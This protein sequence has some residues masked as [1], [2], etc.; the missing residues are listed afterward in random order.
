MDKSEL[1]RHMLAARRAIPPEEA[2]ARS[3]AIGARIVAFD[4][5][6]TA[7]LVFAYVSS[8]DNEV[9]TCILIRELLAKGRVVAVPKACPAGTMAWRRIESLDMLAWGS[10]GILEPPDSCPLTAPASK[11]DVC[12]VPGIAFRRDGFRV[13]YG[14]GYFDRF[15]DTFQGGAIGLAYTFQ[16]TDDFT[17]QQHDRPV[18]WLVTEKEVIRCGA[19]PFPLQ[20]QPL[21]S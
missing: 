18:Q 14:G 12:L 21:E 2:A 6:R 1:R 19:A 17:P 11:E 5:F 20:N 16:I 8:K 13:G 9:D 15:L 7:P 4:V 10:F 3:A